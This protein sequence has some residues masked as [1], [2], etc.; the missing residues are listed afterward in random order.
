MMKKKKYFIV[1][2]FLCAGFFL[3]NIQETKAAAEN[4]G[5]SLT[6]TQTV[7]IQFDTYAKCMEY[8]DSSEAR[9]LGYTDK[10]CSRWEQK[11]TGIKPISYAGFA[12]ESEC[13][14]YASAH[15]ID[16]YKCAGTDIASSSTEVSKSSS[17]G[18]STQVGSSVTAT[19]GCEAGFDSVGGVCFPTTTGLSEAPVI[20]IIS[21]IFSWLMG[22]FTTLAVAAFVVSGIQYLT[23]VGNEDQA[24]IAKN[25]AKFA[26]LGI[27]IGLSG[28]I[29]VRAIAS[30]LSGASIFF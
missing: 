13:E 11:F 24:K 22:L 9:D 10:V 16:D 23:A 19:T 6:G 7:T 28:F 5:W 18:S 3:A 26:L 21:N 29:V 8:M 1:T 4:T 25:N 12:T 30:A 27:I 17:S 20:V 14:S 2:L 15:F